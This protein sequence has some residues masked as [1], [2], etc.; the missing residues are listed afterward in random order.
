[1]AAAFWLA[2]QAASAPAPQTE[3]A[4][5]DFDLANVERPHYDVG[6]RITLRPCDR[7]DGGAIVVCGRRAA[8]DYPMAEWERIF[9]PEGPLRAQR[10][11]GGGAVASLDAETVVLDRGAVANRIMFTFRIPF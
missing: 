11:I 9:P 3:A 2:L 7:G 8:G 10:G 4:P 1:M 6:D 5:V